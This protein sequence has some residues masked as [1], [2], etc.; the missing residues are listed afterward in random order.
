M[1]ILI[2]HGESVANAQGLLL[3]RTDAALTE[4]GKSQ[5]RAVT[6]LLRGPVAEVPPAF[7]G[8]I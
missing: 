8:L 4:K 3:G 2:R 7:F 5:A 6:Q 1:L